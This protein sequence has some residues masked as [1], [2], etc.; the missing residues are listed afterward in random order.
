LKGNKVIILI[1]PGKG[2]EFLLN[3]RPISLLCTTGNQFVKVIIKI[4]QRRMDE[5]CLFNASQLG[6]RARHSTALQRMRL[7]GHVTL[8]FDDNMFMAAAF[9]DIEKAFDNTWHPGLLY[10]LSNLEF[11]TSLVRLISSFLSQRKF[12]VSVECE[13]SVPKKM[14]AGGPQCSVL[15]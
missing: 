3:V 11:S 7:K 1:E 14:Q 15:I 4:V 2:P 13:M 8:N 5:R 9:L 12:R 6:F 10:K